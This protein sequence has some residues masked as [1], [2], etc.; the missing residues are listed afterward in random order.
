FEGFKSRTTTTSIATTMTQAMRDGD[1]SAIPTTLLDPLTRSGT[2]PNVTTSVYPGNQIPST[3]FDKASL[4]LMSK[5]FPLP[6]LPA[7]PGLPLR[8]YQY[9]VKTPVDKTQF[10]HRIDFT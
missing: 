10:N 8:N 4:L 5:F 3:R 9:L 2:P 1:F 7:A 6:N